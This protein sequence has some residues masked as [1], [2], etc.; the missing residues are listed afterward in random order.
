MSI[1]DGRKYSTV[2]FCTVQL[3]GVRVQHATG[4]QRGR[5]IRCLEYC[6]TLLLLLLLGV[7]RI[8]LL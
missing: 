7:S 6:Q 2:L 1:R 3:T 8:D 4:R 5:L